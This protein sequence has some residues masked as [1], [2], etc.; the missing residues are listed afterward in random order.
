MSGVKL[1]ERAPSKLFEVMPQPLFE[2]PQNADKY[3]EA[4]DYFCAATA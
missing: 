3:W 2:R 4:W 1:L